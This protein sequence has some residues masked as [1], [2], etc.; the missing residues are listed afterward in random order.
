VVNIADPDSNS[1]TNAA[2]KAVE[3]WTNGSDP[4]QPG[5]Q[6]VISYLATLPWQ[7]DP[8]CINNLNP[9]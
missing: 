6:A 4:S 7:P 5:M 3:A 1:G 2:F 8:N 9:G